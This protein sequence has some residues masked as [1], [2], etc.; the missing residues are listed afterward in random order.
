MRSGPGGFVRLPSDSPHYLIARASGRVAGLRDL[1]LK[2]GRSLVPG[3]A[4][5]TAVPVDVRGRTSKYGIPRSPGPR[6]CA[7]GS[8]RVPRL[9]TP[10]VGKDRLQ[11]LQ[12]GVS[13]QAQWEVPVA[14]PLAD[15]SEVRDQGAEVHQGGRFDDSVV[16]LQVDDPEEA[17]PPVVC[18]HAP[19]AVWMVVGAGRLRPGRG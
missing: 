10:V 8:T 5:T 13:L 15:D 17:V 2:E 1:G 7:G 3:R 18:Q 4:C 9:R 11:P 14:G 19:D 16:D 6:W 12:A